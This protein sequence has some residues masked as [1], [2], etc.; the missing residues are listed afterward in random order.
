L[1]GP[2]A[3]ASLRGAHVPP[4]GWEVLDHIGSVLKQPPT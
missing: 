4:A 1:T 3:E 2:S